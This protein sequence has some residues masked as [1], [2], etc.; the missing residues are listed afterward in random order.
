[1]NQLR[2]ELSDGK[3]ELV[4]KIAYYTIKKRF[5]KPDKGESDEFIEIS[6]KVKEYKYMFP[7][8]LK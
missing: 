6:N 2:T 3:K 4:P 5:E 1:M 7:P 8:I